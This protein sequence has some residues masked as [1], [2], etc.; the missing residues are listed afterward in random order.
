VDDV[1]LD[2]DVQAI[3]RLEAKLPARFA[4]DRDLV[5]GADLDA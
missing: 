5:L 4:W 2:L 3:A 1:P